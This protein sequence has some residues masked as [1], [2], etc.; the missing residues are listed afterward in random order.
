MALNEEIE[1]DYKMIDKK[2][3]IKKIDEVSARILY[4]QNEEKLSDNKNQKLRQKLIA[5]IH[6]LQFCMGDKN[7]DSDI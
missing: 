2:R 7:L 1:E 3:I 6:A 4:L 5:E